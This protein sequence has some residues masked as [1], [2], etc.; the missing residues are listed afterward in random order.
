VRPHP[1]HRRLQ[2]RALKALEFQPLLYALTAAPMGRRRA[3]SAEHV[4]AALPS[5]SRLLLET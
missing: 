3:M 1:A 4:A 2:V 5:G